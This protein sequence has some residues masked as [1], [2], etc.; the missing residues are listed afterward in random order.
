[1][2]DKKTVKNS[3]WL[4]QLSMA[5]YL[6]PQNLP[7]TMAQSNHAISVSCDK[8]A[9]ETERQEKYAELGRLSISEVRGTVCSIPTFRQRSKEGGCDHCKNCNFCTKRAALEGGG[10][11]GNGI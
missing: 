9:G 5:I 1:M 11:I 4:R 3:T 8:I 6:S 2:M 10:L 7:S